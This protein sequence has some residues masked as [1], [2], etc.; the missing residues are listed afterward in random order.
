MRK[1]YKKG[2]EKH[3]IQDNCQRYHMTIWV[4]HG[5]TEKKNGGAASEIWAKPVY[6]GAS[7]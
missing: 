4:N 1:P 6:S 5:R 7:V 2:P 3:L